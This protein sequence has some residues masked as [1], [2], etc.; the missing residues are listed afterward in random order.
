MITTID[1]ALLPEDLQELVLAKYRV[2][3]MAP[4][5]RMTMQECAW[6][7]GYQYHT[8]RWYASQKLIRTSGAGKFRRI[9]HAAMRAYLHRKHV[10]GAPRKAY[11]EAQLLLA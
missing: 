3:L 11:K 8:I 1:I 4:D 5:H 2:A 7:Y 10:T 6:L 9:T